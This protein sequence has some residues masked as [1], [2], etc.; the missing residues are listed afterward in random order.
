MR[1]GWNG[2][3]GSRDPKMIFL[4]IAPNWNI[5]REE[6]HFHDLLRRIGFIQ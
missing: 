4:K 3:T 6:P 5:L 1:L 2:V